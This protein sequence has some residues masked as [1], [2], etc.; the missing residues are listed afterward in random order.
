M[1]EID[2]DK[3]IL[4]RYQNKSVFSYYKEHLEDLRVVSMQKN[5]LLASLSLV[6]FTGIIFLVVMKV[7]NKELALV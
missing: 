3:I 4:D 1:A 6:I 2:V 5:I 7:R